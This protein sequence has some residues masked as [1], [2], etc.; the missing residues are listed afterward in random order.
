MVQHHK[1]ELVHTQG[2]LMECPFT[3]G[4]WICGPSNPDGKTLTFT[5]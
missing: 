1:T 5:L 2:L 4:K 3:P